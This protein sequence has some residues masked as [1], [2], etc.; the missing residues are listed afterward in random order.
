M[1]VLSNVLVLIIPQA[2]MH[3][4]YYGN[5]GLV[6]ALT[7]YE[8]RTSRKGLPGHCVCT[9]YHGPVRLVCEIGF[10]LVLSKMCPYH[11]IFWYLLL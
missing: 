7:G 6:E 1:P 4:Y 3:I 8:G 9:K 11:P 2:F 5:S 10:G